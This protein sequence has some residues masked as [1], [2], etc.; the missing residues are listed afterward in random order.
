MW[1]TSMIRSACALAGFATGAFIGMLLQFLLI[2]L[3]D[4]GM[5]PPTIG[6][7]LLIGLML[8]LAAAAL[9]SFLGALHARLRF[10]S[11]FP[12]TL[13]VALITGVI[14]ALL[15]RVISQTLVVALLAALIGYVVGLILC[16]LCRRLDLW[17]MEQ[18]R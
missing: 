16:L 12:P 5:A 4:H 2:V 7:A 15:A 14:S 6:Q 1:C 9:M 3:D 17:P 8:G 13:L 18:R 11:L 10:W